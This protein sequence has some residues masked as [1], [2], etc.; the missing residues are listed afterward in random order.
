[1]NSANQVTPAVLTVGTT[2][3]MSPLAIG[4]SVHVE[5]EPLDVKSVELPES[6]G[7]ALAQMLSPEPGS[8]L[9]NARLRMS[10]VNVPEDGT[11]DTHSCHVSEVPVE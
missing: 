2:E 4:A 3:T 7:S 5:V 1:M 6:D 8:V 11:G 10:T 9:P